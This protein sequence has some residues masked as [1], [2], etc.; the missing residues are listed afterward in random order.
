[1]NSSSSSSSSSSRAYEFM[2]SKS[3]KLKPKLFL[4]LGSYFNFID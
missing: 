2:N 3:T 4:M 1:L